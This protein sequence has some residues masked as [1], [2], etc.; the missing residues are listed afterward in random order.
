MNSVLQELVGKKVSVY[1]NQPTAE[2]QDVGVLEA[3]DNY[4][5]K[6]RKSETETVFFSVHLVRMVKLFN[7]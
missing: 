1:S 6:I 5:L 4:W 7:T 2:R 3:V